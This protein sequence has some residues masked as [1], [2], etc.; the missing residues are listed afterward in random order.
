MLLAGLSAAACPVLLGAASLLNTVVFDQ[1]WWAAAALVVIVLLDGGDPRLWLVLGA[2][3][4][5]GLETKDTMV[6]WAIALA[7]GAVLTQ[8]R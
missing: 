2:V 4:G 7:L 3:V 1:L 5:I 6:V 8:G